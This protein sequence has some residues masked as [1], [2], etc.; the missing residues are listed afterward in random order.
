MKKSKEN[1]TL[2]TVH[3]VS[4]VSFKDR[5]LTDVQHFSTK[6]GMKMEAIGRQALR[7]QR[8]W[9]RMQKGGT[10]TIETADLIYEFMAVRGYHFN[11]EGECYVEGR[12]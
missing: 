12:R 6:T 9:E 7:N 11:N 1:T 5:F 4:R 8:F 10:I 2:I 3:R